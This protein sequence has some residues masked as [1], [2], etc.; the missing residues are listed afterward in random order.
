M[1]LLTHLSSLP[2]GVSPLFIHFLLDSSPTPLLFFTIF[3]C[4]GAKLRKQVIER[5]PTLSIPLPVVAVV[6]VVVKLDKKIWYWHFVLNSDQTLSS[7]HHTSPPISSLVLVSRSRL[8][9]FHLLFS[10]LLIPPSFRSS[11]VSSLCHFL[12]PSSPFSALFSTFSSLLSSV[13]SPLSSLHS[14][15]SSPLFRLSFHL[16]Q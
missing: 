15:V 3:T 12:F 8:S 10:S 7:P 6:V 11:P 2:T 9:S 1:S 14:P 4:V 5:A 16:L 13:R